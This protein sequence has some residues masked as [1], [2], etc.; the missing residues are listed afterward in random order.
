MLLFT[1]FMPSFFFI[2][3]FIIIDL[4]LIF[5]QTF[6]W[7]ITFIAFKCIL[8]YCFGD[9]ATGKMLP[10]RTGQALDTVLG[11]GMLFQVFTNFVTFLTTYYS[12]F[13][14]F[15]KL[16]SLCK[17][18]YY[19]FYE[20]VFYSNWIINSMFRKIQFSSSPK[21]FEYEAEFQILNLVLQ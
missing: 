18:F 21:S 9:S 7:R 13:C 19:V 11:F 10:S 8:S 20:E 6:A 4:S 1:F 5:L 15:L 16:F 12:H 17:G 2:F 3:W 14:W